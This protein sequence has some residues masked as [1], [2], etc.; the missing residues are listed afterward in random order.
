MKDM[1][2]SRKIDELGRVVLPIEARKALN[3]ET[4]DTVSFFLVSGGQSITLKK[5]EPSCCC[6]QSSNGLKM[7]PNG[8]YICDS[9]LA[10][11]S[12]QN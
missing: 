4:G 8:K 1:G 5:C 11:A 10:Q 3:M 2:I 9:C 12:L 6:C 7:L